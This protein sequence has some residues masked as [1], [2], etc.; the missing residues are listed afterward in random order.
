[1]IKCIIFFGKNAMIVK[2]YLL[3]PLFEKFIRASKTGK[4][5]T[6]QG[7]RIQPGTIRNYTYVLNYLV[8][9]EQT[10]KKAIR[11]RSA[12]KLSQ[13]E[14]LAEIKYWKRFYLDFTNV[15]YQNDCFDNYVG[16]QIKILKTFFIYL[17]QEAG[18]NTGS[19][20][21][22][23]YSISEDVDIIILVPERLKTLIYDEALKEKLTA[24][25]QMYMDIF[26]VGC[27]VALR[28]GDLNTL[29]WK[30]ILQINGDVYLEVKSRKTAT[31]SKIKL[32]DYVIKILDKHKKGKG[33]KD[34]IF[35]Y[36]SISWFDK[37]IKRILEVAGW[38]ETVGK[39]KAIKGVFQEITLNNKSYRFCDLAASHLMRRTAITTMLMHRVPEAVIK[40]I[41]GH[42]GDSR[43][44]NKYIGLVQPYLDAEIDSHYR[45]M[46]Q[47]V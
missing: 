36:V 22:N 26:V 45:K 8:L 31:L 25:Q 29:T 42:A 11:I 33:N 21:K 16:M 18:I 9:Y 41:S 15:L 17:N 3:V 1:M 12:E 19:V 23:L 6:R 37:S 13:K 38:T 20:Y 27:T 40:Q 47:V 5:L 4:R 24:K 28:Y 34:R 10:Y 46:G 30:Q 39:H 35:P 44:F 32:P 7:K 2:E 14:L 43:S